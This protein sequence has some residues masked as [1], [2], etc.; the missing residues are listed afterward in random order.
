MCGRY[1]LQTKIKLIEKRFGLSPGSTEADDFQPS[2]NIGAGQLGLIITNHIPRKLQQAYFG[3]CPSWAK[4]RMYVLNA[5]SEGDKNKKN[6]PT[7]KGSKGII[8]KKMWSEAVRHRR[9]LV[10]ADAFYEGPTK[11]KL[12]KPYLVYLKDGRR[13]FAF[14]GVYDDW[15]DPKTGEI[16]RTFAIITAPPNKLMQEIGH[17]RSPVILSAS[18]ANTWLSSRASL[19]DI[20]RLMK[21]PYWGAMNAY[22]VSDKMRNPN[23]EGKELVQP[24]SQRIYKEYEIKFEQENIKLGFGW[25]PAKHR[26]S[27]QDEED[28]KR[29]RT[30]NEQKNLFNQ[31]KLDDMQEE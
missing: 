2:F 10:I 4:K 14:A 17:E 22:R 21:P 12:G 3:Y 6:N 1:V 16:I 11:E 29:K 5:R 23:A 20:T 9:C 25:S 7:Y 15:T 19:S 26:R 8:I 13:P 31:D 18:D 30:F 27:K 28:D 24:I